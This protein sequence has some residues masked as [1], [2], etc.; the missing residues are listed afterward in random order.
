MAGENK[1]KRFLSK[2][3][4]VLLR[5]FYANPTKS[6]YMQELGR[7]FGKKPGVFQRTLN[8]LAEEGILSSEYRANARFFKINRA[9]PL[10]AELKRIIFKTIGIEGELKSILSKIKSVKTGVLY[11]SFAKGTERA[12]S[13]IDLL[14]VGGHQ[15]ENDLLKRLS[16]MEKQIHREINYVIYQES[17]FRRKIEEKDPFVCDVLADK[18]IVLKGRIHDV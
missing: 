17:E 18:H 7:I 4:L 11:G 6:F 14:I 15:A 9:H 2:N 10:Y 5:L 12:D 8:Q 13:D 16:A 1:M 3:Q